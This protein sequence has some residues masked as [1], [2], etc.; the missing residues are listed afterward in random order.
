MNL[1][2]NKGYAG[3]DISI[4]IIIILIFIPTIF[5]ITYNIQALNSET[6]REGIA[7]NI[8]TAILEKAK[9]IGYENVSVNGISYGT[10][11]HE[12]VY[13][14]IGPNKEHYKIE[15]SVSNYYP[16]GTVDSEKKDLIKKVNAKVTYPVGNTEKKV[17]IST[18]LIKD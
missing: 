6:Q 14:H 17:E 7:L 5:A 11:D 9:A 3:I 2:K 10:I 16:E 1:K 15:I 4:S 18:A 8:A 13:Y 12:G